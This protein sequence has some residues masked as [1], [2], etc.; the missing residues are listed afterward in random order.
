MPIEMLFPTP[1]MREKFYRQINETELN[2]A[3]NVALRKNVSNFSSQE[4][5]VLKNPILNELGDWITGKARQFFY[6]VFQPSGS[7]DLYITQSWI[8]HSQVGEEHHVHAH[9]NSIIS[10]VFYI[11]ADKD[12]DKIIFVKNIQKDIDIIP[13]NYNVFNSNTWFYNIDIGELIL[14]PSTL[15]HTVERVLPSPKRKT[16]ISL[17]FNTFI[18]GHINPGIELSE[19][20][21]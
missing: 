17:S 11:D 20:I 5:Y 1:I 6:D 12:L 2:Y 16:R 15:K 7:I 13:V 18:K 21:L 10:G 14:F 3:K 9:P 4:T 19:L 8:N